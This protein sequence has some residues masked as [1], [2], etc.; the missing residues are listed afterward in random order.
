MNK[1]KCVIK[2]DNLIIHD[3]SEYRII[4]LP[5]DYSIKIKKTSLDFSLFLI[6]KNSEEIILKGKT[7]KQLIKICN[8]LFSNSYKYF[9]YILSFLL[10]FILIGFYY[11]FNFNTKSDFINENRYIEK[12]IE[13]KQ[14]KSPDFS[15]QNID[16]RREII[17]LSPSEIEEIEIFIKSISSKNVGQEKSDKILSPADLLLKNLN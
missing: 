15:S 16:S 14:I 5:K 2:G 8:S 1:T 4:C 7:E 13:D 10:I 12:V 3:G 6:T 17:K 11:F 9:Y